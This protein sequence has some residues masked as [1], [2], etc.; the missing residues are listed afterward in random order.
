MLLTWSPLG[1]HTSGEFCKNPSRDLSRIYPSLKVSQTSVF[2]FC[3]CVRRLLSKMLVCIRRGY[4]SEVCFTN[5]LI[6]P[7][8]FM[9]FLC[10]H[11]TSLS[12]ASALSRRDRREI[13]TLYPQ[14]LFVVVKSDVTITGL[15]P[16]YCSA[17]FMSSL[18]GEARL[19]SL[20]CHCVRLCF[21]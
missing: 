19:I 20:T 15:S 2:T 5:M 16:C 3:K 17:Q 7:A 10:T 1:S 11:S 4:S 8:L 9:K 18:T 21:F 14:N 6:V 12:S 13:R